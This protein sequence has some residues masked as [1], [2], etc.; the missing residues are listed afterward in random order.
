VPSPSEEEIAHSAD[1]VRNYGAQES[2]ILLEVNVAARL[3]RRALQRRNIA[4]KPTNLLRLAAVVVVL[5]SLGCVTRAQDPNNPSTD[6]VAAAARKARE[7]AKS[8]EK[9]KKVLTN[10]DIPSA[11]L[12]GDAP[13]ADGA[14][15]KPEGTTDKDAKADDPKSEVYWRKRFQQQRDKIAAAEK[16]LDILQRELDKAQVQYYPD[17]QK[18]LQQGFDRSDINDKTAKIDAK[19]K[20]ID[21]LN[22]G[23]SDLE[24]ELRK[25]GGD[26]GW[27]R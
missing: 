23:M 24:D 2:W 14:A 21:A 20:E 26:S 22:Q 10:D 7:Q 15:A 27:A 9:P 4:M 3:L 1:S 19:K 8:A 11:K 5:G 12:A 18:A 17:P 6:D 25:A 13:A 16:E